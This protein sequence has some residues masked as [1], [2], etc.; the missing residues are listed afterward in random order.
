MSSFQFIH[1]RRLAELE[2]EYRLAVIDLDEHMTSKPTYD[3]DF[4]AEVL[5]SKMRL[6]HYKAIFYAQNNNLSSS[7]PPLN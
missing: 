7:I 5:K 6:A 1:K 3:Y 4:V 2:Y